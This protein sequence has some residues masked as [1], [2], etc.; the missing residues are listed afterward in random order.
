MFEWVPNQF[1]PSK[2]THRSFFAELI[3][4]LESFVEGFQTGTK[5]LYA[6][7]CC[8]RR[9]ISTLP[10]HDVVQC[11]LCK[12]IDACDVLPRVCLDMNQ[13]TLIETYLLKNTLDKLQ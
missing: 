13:R 9:A 10:Q 12:L 11:D 8:S 4:S 7:L 2:G 1:C 5:T 6:H 3:L